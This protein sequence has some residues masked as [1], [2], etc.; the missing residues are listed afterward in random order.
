VLKAAIVGATDQALIDARNAG[1]NTDIAA[2]FK[3]D[4]EFVVWRSS[5]SVAEVQ[6]AVVWA[7]MTPADAPDGTTAWTNRALACQGKQFNLQNLIVGRDQINSGKANIRA[8]LQDALTNVPSGAGGASQ[9]AGWVTIRD[10]MKRN[11]NRGEALYA[12]GTG[13]SATPGS[14]V[15][16]GVVSREL[17]LESMAG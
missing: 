15:W 3:A 16:E 10:A 1:N 7:N 6:D 5:V 12:T 4:S 2:W 11:A 17:V 13:T 8:G 9:S 14:L